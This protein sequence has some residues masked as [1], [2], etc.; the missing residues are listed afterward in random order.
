LT[1]RSAPGEE[2]EDG[3]AHTVA[4]WSCDLDAT[5]ATVIRNDPFQIM[6]ATGL[7]VRGW[8]KVR[9]FYRRRI[10][11]FR[12]QGFFA[13]RWV[14]TDEMIVGNSQFRGMPKGVFFG[15]PTDGKRLCLPMTVWICFADGLLRGEATYLDGLEMKRQIEQGAPDGAEAEEV[16]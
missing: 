6:H 2:D 3:H 12:G 7:H 5:M 1:A 16:W 8:A 13:R 9:A 10:E 11:T 4:E 15:T 14:V